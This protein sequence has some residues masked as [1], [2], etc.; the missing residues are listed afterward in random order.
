MQSVLKFTGMAYIANIAKLLRIEVKDYKQVMLLICHNYAL[1]II[2]ISLVI[3]IPNLKNTYI[4][5]C[6]SLVINIYNNTY[7]TSNEQL[8]KY[9]YH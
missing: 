5:T 4:T 1:I 9:L 8:E 2:A 6:D 3:N 7:I